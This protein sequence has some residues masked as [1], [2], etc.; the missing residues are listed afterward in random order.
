MKPSLKCFGL[1][2]LLVITGFL[3]ACRSAPVEQ[4]RPDRWEKTYAGMSLEEFKEVWPNAR[5]AGT[6]QGGGEIYTVSSP[7][8]PFSF[9]SVEYFFFD[10]DGK[11]TKWRG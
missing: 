9:P 6:D 7:Y 8:L 2:T 10:G 11:L 5:Y 3:A 4:T 1:V